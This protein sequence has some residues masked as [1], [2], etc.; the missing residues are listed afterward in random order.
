MIAEILKNETLHRF[1]ERQS[2]NRFSLTEMN[3]EASFSYQTLSKQSILS[4]TNVRLRVISYFGQ[5]Y[6]LRREMERAKELHV[7]TR[8]PA[9]G[10]EDS[11]GSTN[12][13]LIISSDNCR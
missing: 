1:M 3:R 7:H 9:Q 4:R 5:S 2:P 11:L 12:I 8:G 13:S 6:M 10:V